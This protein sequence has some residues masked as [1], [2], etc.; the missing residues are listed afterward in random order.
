MSDNNLFP[1]LDSFNQSMPPFPYPNGSMHLI[2]TNRI[3]PGIISMTGFEQKLGPPPMEGSQE[4]SLGAGIEPPVK[5]IEMEQSGQKRKK[6]G[7]TCKKTNCLKM[8]CDCFSNG[9]ACTPACHCCHC[10]ND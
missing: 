7:C 8:Y 3:L 6:E 9:R 5:S 4:D 2:E 10:L 1:D